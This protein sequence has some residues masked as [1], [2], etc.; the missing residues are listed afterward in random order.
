MEHCAE[1]IFA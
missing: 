1:S